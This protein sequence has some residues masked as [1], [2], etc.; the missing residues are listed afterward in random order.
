LPTRKPRKTGTPGWVR[1]GR[2]LQERRERELDPA[3]YNRD[4]FAAAA[5]VNLRLA[6]EIE[7]NRRE[8]ITPVTLRDIVAPGYQV[9]FESVEAVRDEVPGAD[10]EAAP[11]SPP[12]RARPATAVPGPGASRIPA[13]PPGFISDE[14][15][16]AALP[17]AEQIWK[18]LLGLASGHVPAP[19]DDGI[20]DPGGAELFGDG[21]DAEDWDRYARRGLPLVDRMW[22]VAVLRASEAAAHDRQAG[23]GLAVNSQL[24]RTESMLL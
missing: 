4:A 23:T 1:L 16:Q 13:S 8:N 9:T 14:M 5:G 11:G 15:K 12:R 7:L 21:P 17:F 18:N 3:W 20:P 24:V 10:L 19:G 22:L 2:L 6:Q